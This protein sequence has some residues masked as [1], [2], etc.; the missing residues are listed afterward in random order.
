MIAAIV[1]REFRCRVRKVARMVRVKT[2]SHLRRLPWRFHVRGLL[3]PPWPNY[4]V[5]RVSGRPQ[6]PR[7]S[8]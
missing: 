8:R 5:S 4:G 2:R 3:L 1:L 7:S 6:K